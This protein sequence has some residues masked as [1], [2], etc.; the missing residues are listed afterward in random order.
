MSRYVLLPSREGCCRLDVSFEVPIIVALRGI[1][2]GKFRL[3]FAK[4]NHLHHGQID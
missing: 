3:T 2:S 1:N 4:I